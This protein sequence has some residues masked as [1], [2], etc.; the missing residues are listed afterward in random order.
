MNMSQI[1]SSL[2]VP[3]FY[4]QFDNSAAASSGA[5]PWKVLIIAS[6]LDGGSAEE[7]VPVQVASADVADELFGA[8]SQAALM[9]KAFRKNS[10]FMDLW[11][12]PVA[13]GTTKA[14]KEVTFAGT[15]TAKGTLHLYVGGKE[16]NL[17]IDSGKTA[18]EVASDVAVAITSEFPVTAIAAA[19]VVTFTAKN[20]GTAGNSID[21]RVNYASGQVLPAGLTCSGTGYLAGG[22]GD[23]SIA[24]VIEN[25]A[26]QTYNIIVA[27]FADSST[28]SALK[29]ELDTRMTATVQ[30]GGVAVF[31]DNS[32]SASSKVSGLNSEVLVSLP[33]PKSPTP[34][35]EIAAAG[36]AVIADS[37]AV[38]PA[39]PLGN[40]AIKG[41]LAPELK[42]R[43]SINSENL[44][45]QAGGSLLNSIDSG[46][47]YLR[48]TVTTYKTNSAGAADDSYKQLETLLTL[49]FIRWDWNNY[50]ATK[51]PRAKLARDDYQPG[52]GQ[53]V[54]TPK[55]GRA[56][57]L[58][59]FEYWMSIGVAQ[60]Q[61]A[62][63]EALVVEINAQNPNRLDFLL[64]VPLMRQ[65]FTTAS[66]LQFR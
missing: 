26:S 22:D 1:P 9:T 33:L 19:G 3:G 21:V 42:D 27:G 56:E 36:A 2:L 20:G 55:K 65:L 47:V 57:A 41:V 45:L 54:I 44:L 30:R 25:I 64:P 32:A 63:N 60:D 34:A 11:V 62:F 24:T 29:T 61:A 10:Q 43:A 59:R 5:M 58:S 38:D 37:A 39:M 4:T 15:T 7:N 8:G 17:S 48:Q 52:P 6:M 16:I 13:D 23:P 14:T 49:F 31:G 50:M 28:L 35:F 12:A 53:V 46:D 18:T 40:I 51:Y 66:L